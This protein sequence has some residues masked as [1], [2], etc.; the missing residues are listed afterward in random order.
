M[1]PR[2]AHP[3]LEALLRQFP[4]VLVLGPRQC[5]K[6]TLAKT[7]QP[8]LYLD[9]ELPSD[10]Q[11]LAAD[12]EF[13]LR[14][15][16]TP[17]VIDEAQTLPELFPALRALI[18]ED[19]R[20]CGRFL[21]LGSVNPALVAAV[22]ESLA[23]RVGILELTP[24]LYNEVVST[25]PDLETLWFR[26]GFPDAFLAPDQTSWKRWQEFFFR[27]FVERDLLTSLP[28]LTPQKIYQ[29]VAMLA[30]LQGS[31][32]NSSNLGRALGASYHTVERW[33]ELLEAHFL[34]RRL[35]PYLPNLGKRYVKAP[36]CYLRDSGILHHLLGL[37]DPRGLYLSPQRGASFEG[38]MIE[39]VIALASLGHTGCRPWYY[40]THAGAELDLVLELGPVRVGL[41]F[42]CAEALVR[43]DWTSLRAALAEGLITRGLVVYLGTRRFEL[44]PQLEA[45]P[46]AQLL[47]A[48]DLSIL[49]G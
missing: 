6:T 30:H 26:G 17:V 46:A 25:Q 47:T 34:V 24:F 41:E 13:A 37:D 10:R 48:P 43:G 22:S 4:A 3:I 36:K 18:D 2:A 23:G 35:R 28:A 31:P 42:K 27:T 7:L 5:G 38:A 9:L 1:L 44:G 21:L 15:L 8:G 16:E 11:V 32:L 14:R 33:L 39:Q 12:L 49:R 45:L 19:R 20:R 40:R 29:L